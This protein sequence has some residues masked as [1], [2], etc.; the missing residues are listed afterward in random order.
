MPISSK[1]LLD[2]IKMRNEVVNITDNN[3]NTNSSNTNS[4]QPVLNSNVDKFEDI[5]SQI[6]EYLKYGST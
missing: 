3:N 4:T 2:R 5:A 6:R 1:S